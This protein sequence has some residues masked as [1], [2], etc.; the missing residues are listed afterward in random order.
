M[1]ISFVV[2]TGDIIN[3]ERDR[4]LTHAMGGCWHEH[5]DGKPV[6]MFNLKG[7]IC[8]KCGLFYSSRN[9]FST[10]E[11]FLKLYEWAKNDP[12]IEEF[13]AK[14]RARDFMNEKR[15]PQKRKEFADGLYRLLSARAKE[16]EN[17]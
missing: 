12:G 14:F 10:P 15:G 7:H 8:A 1:K 6:T 11:D 17:V 16:T 3:E 5:G 4:F 2:P 9:D 13:I